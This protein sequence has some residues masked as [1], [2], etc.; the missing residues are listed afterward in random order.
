M[1]IAEAVEERAASASARAAEGLAVADAKARRDAAKDE[2]DF[3]A[4]ML[5]LCGGGRTRREAGGAEAMEVDDA[6]ARLAAGEGGA[7][8]AGGEA[9]G[10]GGGEPGGGR[11]REA[12]VVG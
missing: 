6:L 11:R 8:G 1:R 4:Q 12:S 7:E 9:G 5:R 2:R 3:F 10:G